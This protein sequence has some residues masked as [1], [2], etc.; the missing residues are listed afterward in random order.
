MKR[1]I[2]LILL[3]LSVSL[4]ADQWRGIA[5]TDENISANTILFNR[6]LDGE[7]VLITSID[8]GKS[9]QAKVSGKVKDS[10]Y[11]ALLSQ[12]IAQ[13]LD[14]AGNA[15]EIVIDTTAIANKQ[16][17]AA[18]ENPIVIPALETVSEPQKTVVQ[19]LENLDPFIKEL[20]TLWCIGN[21]SSYKFSMNSLPEVCMLAE[22]EK[23]EEP[24]EKEEELVIPQEL[25]ESMSAAFM[26]EILEEKPIDWVE[27]LEA[28]KIYIKVISSSNKKEL[29][30]YSRTISMFFNDSI[31]LYKAA[32][33]RYELLL[34]P[35]A[36]E[37]IN[38]SIRVVR[39]YGYKDAYLVRG[40]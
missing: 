32:E 23:T 30:N 5:V 35:I 36:K 26:V 24:K 11:V 40:K 38:Q 18:A 20:P 31:I 3:T 19:L 37:K 17:T 13:E 28:G 25:S 2:S 33:L 22:P 1:I 34:G 21:G 9:I 14:I 12:D 6:A 39:D 29:E 4:F 7:T 8:S 15:G 10:R 16:Q 27:K